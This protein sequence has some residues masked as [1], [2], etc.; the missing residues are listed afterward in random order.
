[1]QDLM[2][3]PM[4]LVLNSESTRER[5]K[6]LKKMIFSFFFMFGFTM[7]NIKEDKI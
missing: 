4:G 7:E 5:K 6:K 2:T 1:M 3:N